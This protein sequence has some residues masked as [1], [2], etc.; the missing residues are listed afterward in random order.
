MAIDT[1][2]IRVPRETRDLLAEQA[3]QRGMSLSALLTDL[4]RQATR[5][6]MFHAE[7]EATMRDAASHP[8]RAE[9]REWEAVL[10]DGID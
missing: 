9:E 7:R 5:A 4:A 10:A 6:A 1:A 8:V 2:T 3:R